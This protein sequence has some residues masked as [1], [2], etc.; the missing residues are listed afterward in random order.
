MG[1]PQKSLLDQFEEQRAQA[2]LTFQTSQDGDGQ[3]RWVLEQVEK[4]GAPV[5][6]IPKA[7]Q[8]DPQGPSET[9][10]IDKLYGDVK[11]PAYIDDKQKPNFR[12]IVEHHPSVQRLKKFGVMEEREVIFWFPLAALR[13][14]NLVTDRNFRG[15]GI[16]DFIVWDGTWYLTDAAHRDYYFGQTDRFYFTGAFCNRYQHNSLPEE[17]TPSEFRIR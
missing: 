8:R 15:I 11:N 1:F 13:N 12:S 14:A 7:T 5:I 2:K 3:D 4:L 17:A 16:G 9:D 10:G 6:L